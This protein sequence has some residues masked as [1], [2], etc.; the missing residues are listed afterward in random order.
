M[1]VVGL[2]QPP[3]RVGALRLAHNSTSMDKECVYEQCK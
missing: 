2:Y 1:M 3:M